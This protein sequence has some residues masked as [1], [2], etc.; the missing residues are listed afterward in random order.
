MTADR[1]AYTA[2][3]A[4]S[5]AAAGQARPTDAQYAA[6]RRLL[7]DW[8]G[9]ALAGTAEPVAQILRAEF[10]ADAGAAS[11]LGGGRASIADAAL[12]NGTAGH[13][14][15]YDD[16]QQ[17][18][19]HPAAVVLPAALALAET[20]GASGEELTRAIIAG[21]D[22]AHFVG[23][24]VMPGHYDRGFH[25]TATVGTFGAAAAAAVLMR[26]EG[27]RIEHAIGLAA[28]QA[29]GLKAMFGTMAKPFHAGRAASAGVVAARLAAR[30]MTAHRQS[31]EVEQGFLATQAHQPVPEG[32]GPPAF[33][34]SL[35]R[36]L[37]KYHASCYL[38]HSSIEAV[39][40]L[41]ADHGVAPD[42]VEKL[43]L[44][45]PAGHLK[46][47]NIQDPAT[48]L[49][50]KFS[51]RQV[52]AMTLGGH[53]TADI[54]VFN[55]ALA[56]DAALVRLRARIDVVGDHDGAFGARAVMRL[57]D[58]RTLEASRDVSEAAGAPAD[59]DAALDGKFTALTRPFLGDA[60]AREIL[61]RSYG[62][63]TLDA[64]ELLAAVRIA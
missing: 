34:D 22:A 58:G 12:V 21:Y 44:H 19:G 14:L 47:C 46:V 29:A 25:S 8:L 38:T 61:D 17:Y 41:A 9:V 56:R 20:A 50:S 60:R 51:L 1:Q 26:L 6:V 32:W 2:L 4:E 5:I 33:G 59:L 3:L 48:G 42:D 16:V 40:K 28:T 30:G 62:L 63:P 52:T 45:V 35:D 57:A 43:T 39:R 49:E 7:V 23:T 13:A 31:L 10:A 11:V 18:V 15:D 54:A 53:D 64:A 36:V 55:D 37:F 27:E 24:L